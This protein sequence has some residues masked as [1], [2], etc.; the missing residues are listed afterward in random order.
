MEALDRN[1]VARHLARSIGAGF[2]ALKRAFDLSKGLP[3]SRKLTECLLVGKQDVPIIALVAD[4]VGDCVRRGELALHI[5]NLKPEHL[6]LLLKPHPKEA[7]L[8]GCQHV[9]FLSVC[10]YAIAGLAFEVLTIRRDP[11]RSRT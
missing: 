8:L 11:K 6:V 5:G 1:R 9:L 7:E 3:Q 10:A 4:G 2:E